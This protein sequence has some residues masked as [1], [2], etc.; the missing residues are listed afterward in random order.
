MHTI[1]QD[2]KQ[3]MHL[4]LNIF[5]IPL[6]AIIIIYRWTVSPYCDKCCRFIPSCSVYAIEALEN[7]SLLQGSMLIIKRIFKCHPWGKSG[8]DPI[9]ITQETKN[10][11]Q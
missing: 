5:T 11:G 3:Y 4:I 1:F 8:F 9:P 2:K 10:N 6:I 7:H